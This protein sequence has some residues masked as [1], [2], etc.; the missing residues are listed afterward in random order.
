MKSEEQQQINNVLGT[1]LRMMRTSGLALICFNR[2]GND[3]LSEYKSFLLD[4]LTESLGDR[5][6]AMV[7]SNQIIEFT[8]T[9]D[10]DFGNF[11]R[12]L[13]TGFIDNSQIEALRK[14]N[15]ELRMDLRKYR[16]EEE[17]EYEMKTPIRSFFKTMIRVFKLAEK[18][19]VPGIGK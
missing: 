7:L 17:L 6:L 11:S 3:T 12:T 5:D 9:P 19:A 10:S 13:E 2:C 18:G 14:E 15:H 4:N 8:Q 16:F 1:M